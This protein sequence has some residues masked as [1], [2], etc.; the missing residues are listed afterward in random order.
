MVCVVYD[1]DRELVLWAGTLRR[2]TLLERLSIAAAAGF[3]AISLLPTEYE[4]ARAAGYRDADLRAAAA[5][6]GVG[7]AAV[8]PLLCWLPQRLPAVA[9]AAHRRFARYRPADLVRIAA[10][11]GARSIGLFDPGEDPVD[12]DRAAEAFAEVCDLAA[13]A[14]LRVTLEFQVYSG[15]ADLAAAAA[16][17]DRAGRPNGGLCIDSWHLHRSGT[18]LSVALVDDVVARRVFTVQL[19]DAGPAPAGVGCRASPATANA[20]REESLH[21]RRLPGGG[22]ADLVGLVRRLDEL[23]ARPVYGAEVFSDELDEA[24]ALDSAGRAG[25]SLRDLLRAAVA[26]DRADPGGPGRKDPCTRSTS[27]P[28][29]DP[30]MLSAGSCTPPATSSSWS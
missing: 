16:V 15:I 29:P 11:I 7:F 4:A 10:A 1:A 3:T 30:T 20:L 6:T 22:E 9:V 5:A 13:R 24:P 19:A 17:V 8:D 18:P 26:G 2:T 14:G 28:P 21:R 23:G 25:E 27:P 12:V